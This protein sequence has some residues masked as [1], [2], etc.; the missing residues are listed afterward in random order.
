MREPIEIGIEEAARQLGTTAIAVLMH[1]KQKR[2]RGR[3]V[4][5]A[6]YVRAEDLDALGHEGSGATFHHCRGGCPGG[7]SQKDGAA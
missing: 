1:V 2:L 3:E 7:C 6:W 5:G 4:N